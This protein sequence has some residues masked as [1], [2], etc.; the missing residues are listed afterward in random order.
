MQPDLF[1]QEKRLYDRL[2]EPEMLY[3]GFVEV[4]RNKGAPGI[5]KVTI[6]DF[7]SN[8]EQELARL[9]EE[10]T[11]WR[12]KPKPV[13]QVEIPK[14][15]TTEKRKLGIPCIRDRVVDS[16]L[17]QLLEPILVP[18]FSMHSY[19]FIPGKGQHDAV[20]AAQRI[21]QSGKETVVDIDLSKFFDR[22][23]HDRLIHRLGT[24]IP[25]KRILRLI[26]MKLR[27]GIMKDGL[28]SSTPEGAIQGSP[29][30]PLLSNVVLDELDKELERRNL[31]FCRYAD[32]CNIF[33]KTHKAGE[34]VMGS[35]TRFI[36]GR[37]KLQ[38]NQRK[39]QVAPSEQ[40]RFLGMT[41][42]KGTVSISK[43]SI[44]RAMEKVKALTPKGTHETLEATME[45]INRWYKGWSGYYSLTQYPS[46]LAKIEAHVRRRLR[47]RLVDQQK[48]RKNLY[49]KLRKRGVSHRSAAKWVF[50]NDKR[51]VLSNRR[52]L[53]KAYP[54]LLFTVEL[55]QYIRSTQR[56]PLKWLDFHGHT[57]SS[58]LEG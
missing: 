55:G 9:S 52:C 49:N 28:V 40:V 31:A 44:N 5:D 57:N 12:Y 50:T 47:S 54:V 3:H 30:S 18:H 16:T 38:V 32:D 33:V 29:L 56:L 34:R 13:R 10:L 2:C 15:G 46:Q 41:I 27:S 53:T 11:N 43:E 4:R 17:K 35:I 8:L 19:G 51:W 36:E 48:S 22:I 26:G 23:N 1:H 20:L 58:S 7:E 21:V 25:D 24:Q 42:V 39:S 14:P 37:L 6:S 45:R